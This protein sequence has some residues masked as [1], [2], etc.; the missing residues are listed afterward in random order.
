MRIGSHLDAY[1]AC[2][3]FK[4]TADLVRRN[5]LLLPLPEGGRK[6]P[7]LDGKDVKSKKFPPE[8]NTDGGVNH[9]YVPRV[10]HCAL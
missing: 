3:T 4:F 8:E 9:Y 10:L 6:T 1:V 2:T 7:C 5:L